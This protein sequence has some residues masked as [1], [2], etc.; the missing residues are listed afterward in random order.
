M[1]MLA[2]MPMPIVMVAMQVYNGQDKRPEEYKR[3]WKSQDG[4][5]KDSSPPGME[6]LGRNGTHRSSG[7]FTFKAQLHI[8]RI[9][10][11]IH[12]FILDYPWM[13]LLSAS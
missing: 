3:V 2:T 11:A 5:D 10:C 8:A 6:I 12:D 4:D 13:Y 7:E 9:Q 1:M